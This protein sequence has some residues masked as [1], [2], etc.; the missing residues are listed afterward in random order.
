MKDYKLWKKCFFESKSKQ[1]TL[2]SLIVRNH[3]YS[4]D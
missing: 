4:P 1:R 3:D 2:N